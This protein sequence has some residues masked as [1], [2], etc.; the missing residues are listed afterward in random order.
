MDTVR[1]IYSMKELTFYIRTTGT[2]KMS[3]STGNCTETEIHDSKHMEV[4]LCLGY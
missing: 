1:K 2:C 4:I 3:I